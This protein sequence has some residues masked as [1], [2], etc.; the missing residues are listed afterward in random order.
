MARGARMSEQRR[1]ARETMRDR[2]RGS[3][4]RSEGSSYN[5]AGGGA[6]RAER[7]RREAQ[8]R[9]S[10]NKAAAQK[11]AA[12]KAAAQ[13]AAAEKA[14]KQAAAAKER[15]RLAKQL[16]TNVAATQQRPTVSSLDDITGRSEIQGF[17][18]GFTS[19]ANAITAGNVVG[20]V[21]GSIAGKATEL[22]VETVQDAGQETTDNRLR[23][24][25]RGFGKTTA[26]NV[27]IGLGGGLADDAAQVGLDTLGPAGS[28]VKTGLQHE[29]LSNVPAL[30][31]REKALQSSQGGSS[32]IDST[33]RGGDNRQSSVESRE[34]TGV[35]PG[36]TD[37][38]VTAPQKDSAI[39]KAPSVKSIN[40]GIGIATGTDKRVPNFVGSIVVGG[41][42]SRKKRGRI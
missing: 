6:E 11:V 5:D 40:P 25:N 3:S 37:T 1:S 38:G 22:G 33:D 28:L 7:N 4:R 15:A 24:A 23:S 18:E 32:R 31:T 21:A 12:Q 26:S 10:A 42:N 19:K 8:Q 34:D 35:S 36:N 41:R 30:G 2:E 9:D 39:V 20:S 29:A 16:K 27:G 14:A 13:K 17:Q